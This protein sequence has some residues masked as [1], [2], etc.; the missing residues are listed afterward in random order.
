M[1]R[2]V[3]P[4][5]ARLRLCKGM[6]GAFCAQATM[7][8]SCTA[9]ERAVWAKLGRGGGRT[10]AL[11]GS[12]RR[13]RRCPPPH[14]SCCWPRR[15]SPAPAP[16]PP[17]AR[18]RL[19][20]TPVSAA[21]ERA[22]GQSRPLPP[23]PRRRAPGRGAVWPDLPTRA[24]ARKRAASAERPGQIRFVPLKFMRSLYPQSS[25]AQ[26]RGLGP[27]VVL[28]AIDSPPARIRRLP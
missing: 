2:L 26:P 18:A 21:G 12:W 1:G 7:S 19:S 15:T 9:H 3:L 8:L 14:G 25:P 5:S 16:A 10:L 17:S 23:C 20:A 6:G 22:G 11:G 24:D 28:V 27:G 4:S 13:S